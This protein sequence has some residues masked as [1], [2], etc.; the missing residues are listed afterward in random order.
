MTTILIPPILMLIF[1]LVYFFFPPKK[2]NRWYG[3]RTPYSMKNQKIWDYANKIAAKYL[4]IFA[5][6]LCLFN[7]ILQL[8][9][10][11]EKLAKALSTGAILLG[12]ALTVI[13]V[14]I[15]IRR[16]KG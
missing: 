14:E 7:G 2:I 15:K 5:I 11:N 13:L 1:F 4:L 16:F 10:K 8:Y 9:L 3:Y 6:L 12:L